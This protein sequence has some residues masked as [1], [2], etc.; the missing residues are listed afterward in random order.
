MR[1]G[2]ADAG[3]PTL[4]VVIGIGEL[5]W[6]CF[7]DARRPGGA[8]ANVAF[9]ASQLGACGLVASRVGR[10]VPGDE[11]VSYL[12]GQG[13]ET[14]YIQRDDE[15]P[16]GTVTVQFEAGAPAYTIHEKVAWD[17]LALTQSLENISS[18]AAAICYG[19]LAQRS[20]ASRKT[21]RDCLEYAEDA[22]RV[23]DVNLR[24]P[25]YHDTLLAESL[26]RAQVAKLNHE[27]LPEI[28]EMFGLR[29][30]GLRGQAAKLRE[31]FSLR[32]VCATRGA[33][34][35]LLLSASEVVDLPGARV[36]TADTV[37][38]GDACTAALACGLVWGWPLKSIAQLANDV[39]GLVASRSGA[40]PDLRAEFADLVNRHRPHR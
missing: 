34:G 16:T 10:D 5:L 3:A 32:L 24:P 7:P 9:H 19:T 1:D 8:P 27:E 36:Q 37:G 29:A 4:P 23:Y 22:W 20:A 11:L 38:A 18:Q 28:T 6:D 40:M 12:S 2:H 39:G 25:H 15:H 26:D 33:G 21:I 31:R 30:S 13:L 35:V 17:Y 14:R